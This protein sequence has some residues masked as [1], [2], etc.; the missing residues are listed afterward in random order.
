[1]DIFETKTEMRTQK[2]DFM[3]Q[4]AIKFIYSCAMKLIGLYT[5]F[6]SGKPAGRLWK[7]TLNGAPD[8]SFFTRLSQVGLSVQP[9]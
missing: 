5:N 8:Q 3:K 6:L 9:G 2:M 7:V 4:V 1:M